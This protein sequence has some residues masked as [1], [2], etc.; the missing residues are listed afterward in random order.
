VV[1]GAVCGHAKGTLSTS[2]AQNNAILWNDGVIGS[3]KL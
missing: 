2:Q 3:V 1:K